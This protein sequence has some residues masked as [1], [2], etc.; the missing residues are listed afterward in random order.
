MT[1]CHTNLRPRAAVSAAVALGA[2]IAMCGAVLAFESEGPDRHVRA[3]GYAR[4]LSVSAQTKRRTVTAGSAASYSVRIRRGSRLIAPRGRRRRAARVR[5]SA[6]RPLPAGVSAVFKPA[7]TRSGA[8]KL[9]LRTKASAKPGSYRIRLVARG[10]LR[11]AS[12]LHSAHTTVTLV[13]TA[14]QP[15]DFTIEGSTAS[16]LA[17]GADAPVEVRI[18]NPHDSVL[19]VSELAVSVGDINAPAADPVHPCSGEDFAVIQFAGAYPLELPAR[20]TRTLSELGVAAS[21]WPQVV[22]ANRPDNQD[23]CKQAQVTLR[24][25][26]TAIGG[27]R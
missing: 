18:T 12:R 21:A 23:G 20:S 6:R 19:R 26:G 5:L 14:P 17:P 8:S 2:V 10:R 25:S 16:P 9:T 7:T 4:A 27:E 1:Q 24:F 13:V 11:R 22:M 15:R 3:T